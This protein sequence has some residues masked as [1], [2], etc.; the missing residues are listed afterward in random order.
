MWRLWCLAF[1]AA[2]CS[3]FVEQRAASTTYRILLKSR[4]AAQR[5]VDIELA[6]DAMPGG[7]LQ[8][9]TFALAYPDHRGFRELYAE[10]TC[11]YAV[12]FV[13]DEWEDA[14]LGRR[15]A[16]ADRLAR[17]LGPLLANCVEA[18]LELIPPTWRTA[19]ARG[20]EAVIAALGTMRRDEVSALLWIATADSVELAIDPMHHLGE[21][22]AITA[23]LTRC[24]ELAPGFRDAGAELLL[25]TLAAARSQ[26]IGGDDGADLFARARRHAGDGALMIDVM[27]ARGSAVARKDRRLFEATLDQIVAADVTRWPERRL[28]NELAMRKARRYLAA[29][30]ELLP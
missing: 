3:S 2:G 14:K 4:E 18:N 10:A 27:F 23:T 28:A 7:L 29:E 25:A 21:I 9:E 30:A 12:G 26:V 11:Q 16:D 1:I 15:D 19:R 13:F 17:R 5:Q 24:T 22:L 20:P 8:L 6:R